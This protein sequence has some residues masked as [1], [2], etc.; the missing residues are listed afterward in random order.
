MGADDTEGVVANEIGGYPV[1]LLCSHDAHAR[2]IER[3]SDRAVLVVCAQWETNQATPMGK[4]KLGE[5]AREGMGPRRF[6]P[7]PTARSARDGL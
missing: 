1:G 4:P 6:A 5:K 2:L 3:L 7:A